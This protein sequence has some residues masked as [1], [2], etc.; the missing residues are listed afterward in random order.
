MHFSLALHYYW[1]QATLQCANFFRHYSLLTIVYHAHKQ[2]TDAI[3]TLTVKRCCL[4]WMF[5][6]YLHTPISIDMRWSWR[7]FSVIHNPQKQVPIKHNVTHH[8]TTTGPPVH[9]CARQFSLEHLHIVRKEFNGMLQ[10]G[11]ILPS[12][13][14]W[15]SPLHMV[16]KKLGG[17]RLCGDY[18]ALNN[19]TIPD[20]YPLL[21]IQEF[22]ANL[23]GTT[24]YHN[25]VRAYNQIPVEETDISNTAVIT[26]FGLFEF[27]HMPFGLRN[28]VQTAD[29]SKVQWSS[30]L[31]PAFLLRLPTVCQ[32]KNNK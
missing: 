13:G 18:H 27:L 25:L 20:R 32:I 15:A 26:P 22:T 17:W 11:I 8:I 10:S 29:L 28:V 21:H 6:F 19:T 23:H 9:A 12:T 1:C 2:L 31:R 7:N 14:E 5:Y 4:L 16:P 30:T 3:T 24:I